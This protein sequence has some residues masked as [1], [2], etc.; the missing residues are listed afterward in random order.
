MGY[1]PVRRFVMPEILYG[2][3]CRAQTGKHAKTLGMSRVL[4]VTDAG[5]LSQSWMKEILESLTKAEISVILFDQVTPNPR[6]TE[7]RSGLVLY[8]KEGCDGIVSVGGGSPMDCAKGI[9]IMMANRRDILEFRGLELVENR[10]PPM[11]FVPSTAGTA[12]EVSQFAIIMDTVERVKIAIVSRKV[13]P[14]I[15]LVDP[16]TTVT[17]GPALVAATGMDVLVHAM[18]A[19]V[20]SSH[21]ELTDLHALQAVRLVAAHLPERIRKPANRAARNG[22][23]MASMQA[24]LAFSNGMLGA[25]HA[26]AHSLGGLLDLPH[27][28]CN[29]ILLPHV[30]AFN[31]DSEPERYD[32]LGVLLGVQEDLVAEERKMALLDAIRRMQ[33]IVGMD[34]GL[35]SVGVKPADIPDLARKAREDPC[36]LTNPKACLETDLRE[37]FLAAM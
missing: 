32:A 8:R 36:L 27:G 37:I 23:M 30:V 18:E 19:F 4:L 16:E 9:G 3:G 21:S 34:H 6:D 31:Y 25:V 33:R 2:P 24:G 22:M 35:A 26:M 20:S 29:A 17:V 15:A 14:D 1:M 5:V 12:S 13:V 10:L 11:V 28:E 7:V